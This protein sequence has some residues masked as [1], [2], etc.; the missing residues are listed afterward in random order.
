MLSLEANLDVQTIY[1]GSVLRV[2]QK[3]NIA[4][5]SPPSHVNALH[6]ILLALKEPPC[7]FLLLPPLTMWVKI[8]ESAEEATNITCPKTISWMRAIILVN[9]S[10]RKPPILSSLVFS[11]TDHLESVFEQAEDI[12][13]N[14]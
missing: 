6:V 9:D 7:I 13:Q 8:I 11:A 12:Q 3:G 5:P 10:E 4:S 2:W 14:W 1:P